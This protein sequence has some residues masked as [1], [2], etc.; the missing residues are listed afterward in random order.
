[1]EPTLLNLYS[2]LNIIMNLN[3]KKLIKKSK[4]DF[5]K[6]S[7][8]IGIEESNEAY[9]ALEES[10]KLRII[11]IWEDQIDPYEGPLYEGYIR[12]NPKYESIYVRSSVAGMLIDATRNLP[13]NWVLVMRAGHRP[14]G[15][16]RGLFKLV[17]TELSESHP[18]LKVDQII[19]K[20]RTYIADPDIKAPAH[21]CG[22]AIDV[23][24]FDSGT[25]KLVD[26]GSQVNEDSEISHLH[27]DLIT[28][29]QSENRMEL[30]TLMLNAGFAPLDSEW[31]H[32]SYG[33]QNWAVFYGKQKAK[34]GI[35]EPQL[36]D[37]N[38]K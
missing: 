16:Q 23:D 3:L 30:L 14:V 17:K 25:G 31:W 28:Q 26:F 13:Q 12:K 2:K 1:M 35:Q 20:T 9:V 32:Y 6:Y 34:Y 7:H 4:K 29:I 8:K 21:C 19:E 18:E 5:T 10:Q 15:V 33:D 22:A 11:P 27:S 36:S 38:K 24:V 37:V